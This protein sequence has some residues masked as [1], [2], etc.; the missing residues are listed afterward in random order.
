MGWVYVDSCWVVKKS[1]EF[2]NTVLCSAQCAPKAALWRTAL[3]WSHF[4]TFALLYWIVQ[5]KT[6]TTKLCIVVH[7]ATDLRL[8]KTRDSN[9]AQV[10]YDHF[11]EG[12]QPNHQTK[13]QKRKSLYTSSTWRKRDSD[14]KRY[15]VVIHDQWPSL[16]IKLQPPSP[17]TP[18]RP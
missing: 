16:N 14:D 2:N 15:L 3:Y 9:V 4:C 6:C 11:R 1:Y 12:G 17:K 13:V 18:Q 7:C 8:W 10:V 5:L